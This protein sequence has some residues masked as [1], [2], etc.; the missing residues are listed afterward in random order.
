V[1]KGAELQDRTF[2]FACRVVRL[3]G[4]LV[5]HAPAYQKLSEQ[6][7][8]SATSVGA[9]LEEADAAQ[10]RAD[11]RSKC[12]IALKE[13]RESH[14]WLRLFAACELV[15]PDRLTDLTDEANQLV[16]ILTTILKNTRS[17]EGNQ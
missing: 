3:H 17:T 16:A 8:K 4:F 5:G 15:P 7:L 12:G 6:L 10:S 14:Y 11:F 2:R 9:N 13:A 1:K